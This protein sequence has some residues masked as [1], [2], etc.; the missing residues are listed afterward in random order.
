MLVRLLVIAVFMLV[1]LPEISIAAIDAQKIADLRAEVSQDV[2]VSTTGSALEL[3]VDVMIPQED[4]FQSL[5]LLEVSVP[6]TFK[7]DGMGNKMV[8]A[9]FKNPAQ[10]VSFQIR[11][12]V[13]VKRR[14]SASLPSI[15]SLLQPTDLI[16]SN[17]EEIQK[18]A[19]TITTGK[20][21]GFEQVGAIA[22]WVHEN[23]KYDLTYADVNLSA[24]RA[25]ELKAGVCD[26][27][28]TIELSMLRSLGY[29]SAYIV[30]YAYGRGY[31]EAEDFVPHGWT[32]TCS[33]DNA[34]CFVAD[35]TWAEVGWLDA[36][37]IKFATLP[38]SYYV[39]ATALA[40]GTGDLSVKL[41]GVN[42][43]I[44]ILETKEQDVAS[45][46]SQ[47]LDDNLWNGYAIVKTTLKADGCIS[48]K[49]FKNSCI[50]EDEPFLEPEVNESI[51]SFCREKILYSL[52]KI[53]PTL[54]SSTRYTCALSIGIG[55]GATTGDVVNL[56]PS[57]KEGTA[58]Q[59]SIDKT[60]LKP[61]EEFIATS[62]GSY[63]FTDFGASSNDYLV[64]K[65]PSQSFNVF[66]YKNGQLSEQQ[67][68]VIKERPLE[69]KITVNET[70]IRGRAYGINITVQNIA[71]AEKDVAVKFGNQTAQAT[72]PAG[73]MKIFV[74]N[75]TAMALNDN[76]VRAF[77]STEGFSTS[78]SKSVVVIEPPKKDF[79]SA[80]IEAIINFF[81]N[82]LGRK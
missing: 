82:L 36:T 76:V 35:P 47:L 65:A 1:L 63:L 31:R 53:P 33:P 60:S 55:G 34:Q 11:S 54:D 44:T 17:D 13:S 59:L 4:E 26:E 25:L 80:I 27:F 43:K 51:E 61:S 46:Q 45:A 37:H 22:K 79:L 73:A 81:K 10:K 14:T 9:I 71:G 49:T 67:V 12:V 21:V 2:S 66:A 39:E 8:N 28:S 15:P 5:E 58:P 69:I 42:T 41:D 62:I 29:N 24:K 70:V 38:D 3:S 18:L 48:T 7:T 40:K 72:V 50:L 75:F 77:V 78:V 19:E 30:G 56:D 57:S 68:T 74:F 52:F 16:Q 32:E 64:A 20:N 6:Y 23:I